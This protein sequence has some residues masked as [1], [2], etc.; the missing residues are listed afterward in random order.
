LTPGAK[1]IVVSQPGFSQ[2]ILNTDGTLSS[3]SPFR[4]GPRKYAA[5][6]D[7]VDHAHSRILAKIHIVA[8]RQ[9]RRHTV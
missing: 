3:I 8:G 4:I 1:V 2:V 7:D 6:T 5:D 9:V